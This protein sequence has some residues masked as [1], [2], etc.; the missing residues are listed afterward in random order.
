MPSIKR[1]KNVIAEFVRH[2]ERG[3]APGLSIQSWPDEDNRISKDID[4]IA[5]QLA[6]EHTS[7]DILD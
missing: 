6:I 2:I 7:I 5:G 3:E 4:A 1:D